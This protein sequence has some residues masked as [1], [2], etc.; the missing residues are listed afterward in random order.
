MD[1][2]LR[3]GMVGGGQGGYIGAAHRLAARLDDCYDF[4]AGALSSDPQRAAESGRVLRLDPARSYADY[5]EMARVEAQREDGIDA[6]V[7]V[8]PNHLHAPVT[9]AFLEAGIHVICDK[10]L[11][12]SLEEALQMQAL[13]QSTGKLLAVTYT[14]SGYAMVRHA[15]EMVAAGELGEVRF[16]HVEYVQDWLA[17]PVEQQ[18]NKQAEWR[19]D[20]ARTGP[21]GCLGDIGTHAYQL[22]SFVTGMLP[23]DIS[24]DVVAMV[25]GRRVDDHVQA[26]LRYP[27]GARGSLF[28]SQIATGEGNAL[29]LRVYG[30]KAS[31]SFDQEHPDF[32]WYTPLNGNPVWLTKGRAH[33]PASD[34]ATRIPAGHP[35]GYFEAFAQLY[36]DAALQI[37]AMLE[38]RPIPAS[39]ALLTTVEDGVQG[40]RF[41]EAALRSSAQA[42]ARVPIA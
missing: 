8:T 35:E 21:G 2:R 15:K 17:E 30:T 25:P 26:I 31:I 5:R 4:V 6:V 13:A 33:S 20:P 32:L 28:A 34:H 18:G 22:A 40:M 10:P 16:V 1:R 42:G 14:Y 29:R 7:V 38:R 11:A 12:M 24:A 23:S 37:A 39:S 27:S 3:L 36:R 9:T 19:T 41:I